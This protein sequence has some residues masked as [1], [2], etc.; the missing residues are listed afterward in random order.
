M[1]KISWILKDD[2]IL[3]NDTPQ[4]N[5]YDKRIIECNIKFLILIYNG[6]IIICRYMG[7]CKP[8]T[9]IYRQL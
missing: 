2:T 6:K 4:S 1:L 5:T 7:I 9:N 3:T 8:I